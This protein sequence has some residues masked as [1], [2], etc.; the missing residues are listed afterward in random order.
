MNIHQHPITLNNLNT[1]YRLDHPLNNRLPN[2][3][4]NL[5]MTLNDH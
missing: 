1:D 2:N 3:L 4:I 5:T